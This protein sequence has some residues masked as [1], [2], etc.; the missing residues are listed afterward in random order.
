MYL[1]EMYV[2]GCWHKLG[3]KFATKQ[4]ADEKVAEFMVCW[5]RSR[6]PGFR[7]VPAR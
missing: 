7:V 6:C 5:P 4:E 3:G 1:I 2:D